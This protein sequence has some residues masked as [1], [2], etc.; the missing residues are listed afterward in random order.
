VWMN[1][2]AAHRATAS[3]AVPRDESDPATGSFFE[4]TV[5]RDSPSRL[6][7]VRGPRRP[8]SDIATETRALTRGDF[9]SVVHS[10]CFA[11]HVRVAAASGSTA[12]ARRTLP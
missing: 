10:P 5:V 9:A 6:E 3:T 4:E 7:E 2:A 12:R 1:G 11:R 8:T